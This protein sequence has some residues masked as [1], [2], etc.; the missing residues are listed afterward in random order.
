M[1]KRAILVLAAVIFLAGCSKVPQEIKDTVDTD[2]LK[3][4]VT[5]IVIDKLEEQEQIKVLK[6]YYEY[7][8]QRASEDK[9][10]NFLKENIQG[11]DEKRV[12][13]MLIELENHLLVKGYDTRGVLE[14][15]SPYLQYASDELKSYFRLWENEIDDQTTDGEASIKP[16]G[17]I[18][19]RA[20][21]AENH[22]KKF[23]EGETR[24]KI[25]ELYTTY[26]KLGIQGLGNQYIYAEDGSSRLSETI[27]EIY[28]GVVAE[29]PDSWTAKILKIYL[30]ELD[31]DSMDMNGPNVNY[32]YNNIDDIIEKKL[33]EGN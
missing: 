33:V 5:E 2:K 15:I 24:D 20:L 18:L 8:Q 28:N 14:K 17:E 30:E 3:D 22:I 25:E 1:K 12:D 32:F 29:N 9:I 26:I 4:A 7:I 10:L 21:E 27:F 23:P 13:E 31:K 16:A 11:L 19:K 6:D